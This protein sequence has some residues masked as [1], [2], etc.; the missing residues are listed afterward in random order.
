M[1]ANQPQVEV[2]RDE[3]RRRVIAA[4][5]IHPALAGLAGILMTTSVVISGLKAFAGLPVGWWWVLGA[6][7]GGVILFLG[8]LRMGVG[9]TV[10][11]ESMRAAFDGAGWAQS[12]CLTYRLQDYWRRTR[13]A[14]GLWRF[15]IRE[16]SNAISF[17]VESKWLH[18]TAINTLKQ[19][20]P[21]DKE[22]IENTLGGDRLEY[23]FT[24]R[25]GV[26]AYESSYVARGMSGLR[27][28]VPYHGT[29]HHVAVIGDF[30]EHLPAMKL[31]YEEFIRRAEF[32]PIPTTLSHAFE[33]TVLTGMPPGYATS[34][35]NA[36]EQRWELRAPNLSA[37]ITLKSI[38]RALPTA[39]VEEDLRRHAPDSIRPA[40]PNEVKSFQIKES[41]AAGFVSYGCRGPAS[42]DAAARHLF[43]AAFDLP[44]GTRFVLSLEEI[45]KAD[46]SYYSGIHYVQAMFDVIATMRE[47][48]ECDQA[49]ALDDEASTPA[50]VV[51]AIRHARETQ[52]TK[53]L[54]DEHDLEVFPEEICSLSKLRELW[55]RKNRI[56]SLPESI[57]QLDN[58]EVLHV[59]GNL[60]T[61]LPG[62]ITRLTRLRVLGVSTNQLSD[63]PDHMGDM[64]ALEEIHAGGNRL[65][66]LP[67]S[68]GRLPHLRKLNVSNN[69]LCALPPE[70]RD[71]RALTYL[72][73]H[74]N[75]ALGLSATDLGPSWTEVGQ[76]VPPKSP[77]AIVNGWLRSGNAAR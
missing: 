7:A 52:A 66:T 59:S 31:A 27:L 10:T 47:H 65:S 36:T 53:L 64:E 63:W 46:E 69:C 57:G 8:I 4:L 72:Y 14:P 48:S 73:L 1:T 13:L 2:I 44:Q 55:L 77:R 21:F 5:G 51:D 42:G 6:F 40:I 61:C 56:R 29:E 45:E 22:F 9:L 25:W 67:A 19:Y 75:P 58:L 30:S 50:P 20:E 54:L 26:D 37:R 11:P 41:G 33:N 12:G 24:K 34:M 60:L 49:I 68:L 35:A 32:R 39:L 23:R 18:E 76:G 15:Y 70:L 17:T 28:V 71:C 3:K 62:S 74:G 43:V 16:A 38:G